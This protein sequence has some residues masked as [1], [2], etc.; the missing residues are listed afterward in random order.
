MTHQWIQ[1]PE[2]VLREEQCSLC[3]RVQACILESFWAQSVWDCHSPGFRHLASSV[4]GVTLTKKAAPL[5]EF[6]PG[7]WGY[8]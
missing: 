4:W 2:P 3:P 7:H 5:L 1:S 8:R 6:L